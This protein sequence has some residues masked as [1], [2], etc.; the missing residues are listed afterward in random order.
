MIETAILAVLLPS[1]W[2]IKVTVAASMF[3]ILAYWY[4]TYGTDRG[5][6]GPDADQSL[7]DNSASP[8]DD[9]SK[10]I[11][12]S[13]SNFWIVFRFITA[14]YNSVETNSSARRL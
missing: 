12:L 10:V 14:G 9:N 5:E 1:W 6:A 11:C 4:F 3:V 13:W 2:E 8:G 7:S